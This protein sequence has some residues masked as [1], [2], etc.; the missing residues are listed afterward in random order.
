MNYNNN[1][2][3]FKTIRKQHNAKIN[4]THR[5]TTT[6]KKMTTQNKL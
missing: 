4:I 6:I 2:T 3:P 5:K 1:N